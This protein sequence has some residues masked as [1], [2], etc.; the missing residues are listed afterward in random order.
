MELKWDECVYA[1][2][3]NRSQHR[4]MCGMLSD[5]Q[6]V[7]IPQTLHWRNSKKVIVVIYT[8]CKI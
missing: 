1:Y 5:T 8:I 7:S 4:R 6:R 3:M 2:S